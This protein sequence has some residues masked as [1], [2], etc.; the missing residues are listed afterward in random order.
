MSQS[1]AAAPDESATP[2][3]KPIPKRVRFEVLRRDNYTCRY[4][5][6]TDA[7]LTIDHVKPTVLGGSDDPSNLVAACKDCNAGKSSSAP[8]AAMVAQ[9]NDDAIRWAQAVHRA[10]EM[11]AEDE[12]RLEKFV[13]AFRKKWNSFHYDATGECIE[14]PP[15]W[16]QHVRRLATQPEVSG[17]LICDA[18]DSAMAARN[19]ESRFHYFLGVVR[20]KVT[21]VH[22]TAQRL[23]ASSTDHTPEDDAYEAA[24]RDGWDAALAI[25]TVQLGAFNLNYLSQAVE[26]AYL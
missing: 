23:L 14:L 11:L 20:N 8:D 5:R 17:K 1:M 12:A 16:R 26:E 10:V 2:R 25:P 9:V 6:A 18:I 19:V 7:P 22:E 3:R 21:A 15:D 24:Y 4:C 13:E